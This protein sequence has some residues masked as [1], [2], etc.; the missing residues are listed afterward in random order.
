M[1]TMRPNT[2]AI[3]KSGKLELLCQK[4]SGTFIQ[5]LVKL[6]SPTASKTLEGLNESIIVGDMTGR[7]ISTFELKENYTT[8]T[9]V[10]WVKTLI[11]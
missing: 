5:S 4:S 2:G 3:Q 1:P 7:G 8:L 11:S 10:M 9:K 6:V